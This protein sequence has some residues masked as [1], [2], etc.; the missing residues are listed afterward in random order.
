MHVVLI[1]TRNR[2]GDL[3]NTLDS[4]AEQ[5]VTFDLRIVLVDASD[6]GPRARVEALVQEYHAFPVQ[7]HRYTGV[8]SAALQRNFGLDHL[9]PGTEVIYFLDDD[10]TL[11]PGYFDGMTRVFTEEPEAAGVGATVMMGE[12]HTRPV[13]S[14]MFLRK[15]FLLDHP[16]QGRVLLSGRTSQAQAIRAPERISVDWFGGCAMAFR[17]KAI[18]DVRFDPGLIGHATDGDLDFSYRVSR[19]APLLVEP[20]VALIHHESAINRHNT[21]DFARKYLVHRYWFLEKNIRHPL[22]KPAF[23]WSTLG[24]LL[25]LLFSRNPRSTDVMKGVLRG[26]KTIWFRQDPLLTKQGSPAGM[27]TK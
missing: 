16:I 4:I 27:D 20:G 25:V 15:L 8:P 6:E 26:V 14:L 21:E 22:R 10:V 17:A 11:M 5:K 9:P 18:Q 7:Y 2:P 1:V 24:R 23:W 12:G 13:P 3:K 19:R